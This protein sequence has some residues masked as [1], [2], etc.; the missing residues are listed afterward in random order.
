MKDRRKRMTSSRMSS[1]HRLSL[2]PSEASTRMSSAS[3]G[4]VNTCA[5]RGRVDD[6]GPSCTGVLNCERSVSTVIGTE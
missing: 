5:S 2:S 6:S 4:T 1:S 3:T